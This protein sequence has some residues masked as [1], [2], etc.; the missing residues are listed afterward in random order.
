MTEEPP[1]GR[2]PEVGFPLAIV[3]TVLGVVGLTVPVLA[4][5]ALALA[6]VAFVMN[7]PHA[8]SRVFSII[9]GTL[10]LVGVAWNLVG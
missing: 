8:P 7:A 5:V 10:G 4:W 3:S 1:R 9:G 2:D 6:V